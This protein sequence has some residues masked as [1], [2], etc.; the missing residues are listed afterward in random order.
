MS[1]KL[2]LIPTPIA[3]G[4]PLEPVAKKLLMGRALDENVVILIEELKI[5]RRMWSRFELA[6]EAFEKFIEF[7]E[8][9]Q[10]DLGPKL[11]GQLKSGQDV[12]L[13][14]DCGL[15]AFCDPGQKL[16]ELCHQNNIR[17]TA[18]PFPN[19][20]ALALALSGFESHQFFFA[21]FVS[22]KSD[23]RKKDLKKVATNPHTTIV[24][25]T[26]YRFNK[27]FDE[28]HELCP[29]RE[30]FIGA[31]LNGS[32]EFCWRDTFKNLSHKLEKCKCEFVMVL[33]S[34]K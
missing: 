18:T 33:G 28:L 32:D 2:V 34:T 17:V 9:S 29:D 27:I 12:F 22:N 14:S 20:V 23:Q 15:P 1:G 26:P 25:D 21:G 6:R 3:Q 11:I 13:L 24:M 31:N 19:S 30:V 16:V 10:L 8:H 5:A 7:N 4:L